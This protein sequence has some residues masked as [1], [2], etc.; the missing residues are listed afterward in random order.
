L[1]RWHSRP[2]RNGFVAHAVTLQGWSS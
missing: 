2:K 1:K